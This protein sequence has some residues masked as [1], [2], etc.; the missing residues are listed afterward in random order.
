VD[1]HPE[2]CGRADRPGRYPRDGLRDTS[3]TWSLGV[4]PPFG[5]T[6]VQ[7]VAGPSPC[8]PTTAPAPTSTAMRRF[9]DGEHAQGRGGAPDRARRAP[10][11]LDHLDGPAETIRDRADLCFRVQGDIS[12]GPL[13]ASASA[14]PDRPPSSPHE[15]PGAGDTDPST[16]PVGATRRLAGSR[17]RRGGRARRCEVGVAGVRRLR[18]RRGRGRSRGLSCCG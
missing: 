12:T 3:R 9:L 15:L 17:T 5:S 7:R 11:L 8:R 14:G 2:V 6:Y 10:L 16:G 18:A 13:L 4:A 1:R